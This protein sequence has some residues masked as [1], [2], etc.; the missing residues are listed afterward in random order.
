MG[1]SESV[2]RKVYYENA[3]RVTPGLPQ[4]GWLR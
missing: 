4:E 3:L 1:L 2:L